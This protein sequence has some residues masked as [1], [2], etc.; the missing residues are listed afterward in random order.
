M[1]HWRRSRL[2]ALA[3]DSA[4]EREPVAR[5][6]AR[7]LWGADLRR[8]YAAIAA[9]GAAAEG[10]RVLDVPCGGGVAFRGLTG[11]AEYVACDLSPF[12]LDRARSEARRRGVRASFVRASVESL[13][14]GDAVF[15]LCLTFFGLHC[16]PDPRAALAEMARVLRPGGELRGTCLVSGAGLRQNALI[17]ASRAVGVFG[18]AEI[19]PALLRTWLSALGLTGVTVESTGAAALFTAHRP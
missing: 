1:D 10:G 5:A 11:P 14:Y 16:F 12:M 13:P 7:V 9:A 6:F 17:A 2:T 15:D 19:T 3:Y 18:P 8:F 4:V